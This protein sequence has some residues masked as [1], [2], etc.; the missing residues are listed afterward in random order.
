VPTAVGVDVLDLTHINFRMFVFGYC[1]CDCQMPLLRAYGPRGLS[2]RTRLWGPRAGPHRQNW[3]R[4]PILPPAMSLLP[5][6]NATTIDT[7]TTTGTLIYTS[8]P[9]FS[10]RPGPNNL[11][12]LSH[13]VKLLFGDGL[14]NQ[15]PGHLQ[16]GLR[17]APTIG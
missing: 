17:A 14:A 10:G 12:E 2:P 6:T 15:S 8:S 9:L 16:P 11:Q 5:V 7:T 1:D 3:P 13:V 4:P